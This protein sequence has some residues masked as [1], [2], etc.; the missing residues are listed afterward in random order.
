[1]D[2]DRQDSQ[3]KKRAVTG[4]KLPSRPKGLFRP[5]RPFEDSGSSQQKRMLSRRGVPTGDEETVIGHP[6]H[7]EI[8]V[9]V[10]RPPREIRQEK[11]PTPAPSPPPPPPEIEEPE[12]T[13]MARPM[14]K[15]RPPRGR[16]EDLERPPIERIPE[17]PPIE[18]E[19]FEQ[20]MEEEETI[21]TPV[22]KKSA[23]PSSLQPGRH[24]RQMKAA[25]ARMRR[26][27]QMKKPPRID[28]A[29]EVL[30]KKAVPYEWGKTQR[31]SQD[32]KKFLERVFRQFAENATTLLAPLL[33]TRVGMEY[34]NARLRPYSMFIQ[35][36][37]EPITLV[38]LRMDPETQG[39]MVL[40]FP[41][42]FA[43]I[44]RCL[45]G[46]GQSLEEMRYLTDIEMAILERVVSRLIES[47][48]EAWSDIRECKPQ[49]MEME[50]N[51]QTVHIVKPSDMMVSVS[52]NVH[53][54]QATGPIYVVIPFEYLKNVLPK[55]NFEEFMLTRTSPTQVGPSVA[56]LFAKN[57][58]QA[59]VPVSVELGTTELLFGE[60]AALEVN[61]FVK[62]DQEITEPLKIKVNEKIKFLGR[63]GLRDKKLSV[64][65][66]R[67]LQ[68][69]DEDFDER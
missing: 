11:A 8:E 36:L 35:S 45:G 14:R 50:F 67:V 26:P 12:D 54:A 66:T 5:R 37:Y 7:R 57:L 33:Q 58:D 65:I 24:Q 18:E 55:N 30:R 13:P 6:Q 63:P 2:S 59:M 21:P 22:R 42:S 39:L 47:Y 19:D 28:P 51:P 44:D 38:T 68:E 16:L 31:F 23:A 62:L 17:P 10:P 61:D 64:Q 9:P 53:V 32:Q 69:G 49:F 34:Q 48:Q 25:Q 56:P 15:A 20:T 40:D 29:E 52:F 41:L 4:H 3:N 43:L 27:V 1:M 60:L 46:P